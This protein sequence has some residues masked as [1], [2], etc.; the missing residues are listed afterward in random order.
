MLGADGIWQMAHG[1]TDFWIRSQRVWKLIG[2][3]A[4]C[5][6]SFDLGC[7]WSK[8]ISIKLRHNYSSFR[9]DYFQHSPDI[10]CFNIIS[11][12]KIKCFWRHTDVCASYTFHLKITTVNDQLSS[13]LEGKVLYLFLYIPEPLTW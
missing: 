3:G 8:P 9:L 4:V 10:L 12:H 2:E 1:L 7:S 11:A 6:W 5:I 13:L